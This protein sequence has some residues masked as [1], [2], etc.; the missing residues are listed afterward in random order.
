MNEQILPFASHSSIGLLLVDSEDPFMLAVYL[1]VRMEEVAAWGWDEAAAHSF[2]RMQYDMQQR[3][4]RTYYAESELYAITLDGV[5]AGKLHV[6]EASD[7]LTLVDIA[8]LPEFRGRGI[9]R[10]LL[11]DLQ[12][13][14]K[15]AGK[16]LR[17]TV[18][19]GNPAARLY[20]RCGFRIVQADEMNARMEWNSSLD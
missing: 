1:S 7:G 17:L 14:A 8:L 19:K 5:Q 3:S 12:Y 10:Q 16:P 9:G 20:E 6:S 18:S 15:E 13:R 2:L 4:Y 11:T